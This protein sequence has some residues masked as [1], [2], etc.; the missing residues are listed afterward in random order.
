MQGIDMKSAISEVESLP[1]LT[2]DEKER[3]KTYAL[4]SPNKLAQT[5]IKFE[6]NRD[7][8][9][10]FSELEKLGITKSFAN[11]PTQQVEISSEI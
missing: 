10:L 4:V 6:S 11:N 8:K 1:C 3:L 5:L 9:L 7:Y 2:Q